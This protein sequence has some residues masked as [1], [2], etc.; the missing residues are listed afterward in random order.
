MAKVTFVS[1]RQR[2]PMQGWKGVKEWAKERGWGRHARGSSQQLLRY[3]V[4]VCALLGM[5]T[6]LFEC[7]W[8]YVV[9]VCGRQLC[10]LRLWCGAQQT[11]WRNNGCHLSAWEGSVMDWICV[12]VVDWQH[13]KTKDIN[14]TLTAQ[15]TTKSCLPNRA[16]H[17]II[18]L[19]EYFSYSAKC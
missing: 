17:A 4:C 14:S 19:M 10:V 15:K 18:I 6:C 8:A 7:V 12:E 2:I 9:C 16:Q 1:V 5:C 13:S 11:C 3:Y